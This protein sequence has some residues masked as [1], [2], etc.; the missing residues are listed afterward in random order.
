MTYKEGLMQESPLLIRQL[1]DHAERFHGDR[2]IVSVLPEGGP[3][4]RTNYR[5]L[6][7]R[8]KA[9]AAALLS[10]VPSIGLPKVHP[11]DVVATLAWNTHRHMECYYAV[12][13]IGA[14]LHTV[15]PRLFPQQI[16]YIVNHA[17]GVVMFLD[18]QFLQLML[19]L[20]AELPNLKCLVVLSPPTSPLPK[21][22]I[23]I[24]SYEDIVK[25]GLRK[26]LKQWPEFPENTAASLCYTSGT[27]GNPKGVLFS[28]RSTV[29]HSFCACSKDSLG[30]SNDSCIL[31][32]VPLFHAN[33]WGLPYAAAMSGAKLVLPAGSLDGESVYSLM[34][35]EKCTM[36]V[37]V[38]TVWLMFFQYL[39]Q[40]PEFDLRKDIK[41]KTVG[42][43]GSAVPKSMIKRFHDQLG[44]RV[45]QIWGMT[46]MSPLGTVGNFLHKHESLSFEQKLDVQVKQGRP[47]FGVQM[48]I[49]DDNGKVL[50]N[51]GEAVG[52]LKVKGPWILRGYFK[53]D[54][55]NVLDKNGFFDTGDVA[56]IDP[57][58]YMQITD[59]SKDVIKS[60]GEWISSIDLENAAV[61]HPKIQEAAV[62]AVYHPKWQERPL[63]V[64]VAKDGQTVTKHEVIEYLKTVVTSWW[65]PD[66][67][68]FVKELPHSA[69]GKLL[70][71]ELRE[72]FKGYKLPSVEDSQSTSFSNVS[73][74]NKL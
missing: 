13:C 25:I 70:K 66:D 36:S 16:Q 64:V 34:K 14:V 42:I 55:G 28:H 24:V 29:L 22:S 2:E 52:N 7:Y 4:L 9:L 59:R 69:T 60:G 50:P 27:T 19:P 61:G 48:I 23:P 33:A 45:A 56:K 41:L 18:N 6:A 20:V 38:P 62:I 8:A 43:G 67:I 5:G 3:L 57:D 37:G 12:S 31:L 15:N 73:I 47:V 58:G 63:L 49:E 30:V 68:V 26:P 72:K 51:D 40:H 11:G 65:L 17:E 44:V 39:D 74:R 10:G 53:G 54:G 46:E 32:I 71:R 35:A 1:L 21:S